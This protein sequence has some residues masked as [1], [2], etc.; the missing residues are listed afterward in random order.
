MPTLSARELILEHSPQADH[1]QSDEHGDGKSIDDDGWCANTQVSFFD[2]KEHV[3]GLAGIPPVIEHFHG[4][5]IEQVV[6]LLVPEIMRIANLKHG[7][8]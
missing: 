1:G 2:A 3:E 5:P 6:D 8:A 4:R 7:R